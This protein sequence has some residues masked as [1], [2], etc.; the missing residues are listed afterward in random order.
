MVDIRALCFML[1]I[2][3]IIVDFH[4]AVGEYIGIVDCFHHICMTH[5]QK[6]RHAHEPNWPTLSST[7]F[8]KVC[9]NNLLL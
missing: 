8:H 6:T 7:M 4:Y 2:K 9:T 3:L 1:D 5:K